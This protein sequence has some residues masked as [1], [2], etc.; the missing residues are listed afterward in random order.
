MWEAIGAVDWQ[1]ENL[2]RSWS[3]SLDAARPSHAGARVR[4][5]R[6]NAPKWLEILNVEVGWV[7]RD[8][9]GGPADATLSPEA[10]EAV[11]ELKALG[12]RSGSPIDT[13]KG[14]RASIVVGTVGPSG[15]T[16]GRSINA[17]VE[18]AALD[19]AEKLSLANADEHHLFVW[20]D[21]TD[22]AGEAAMVT[23]S[24]PDQGPQLP[25]AVDVVWVA[26]WMRDINALTNVHSLWRT[27]QGGLWEVVPVPPSRQYAQAITNSQG[28]HLEYLSDDDTD[29]VL[30]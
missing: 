23:F 28:E 15:W 27:N 16:D 20:I 17:A 11:A 21:S 7:S 8:W 6:R 9:F 19:N 2:T 3:V 13:M 18:K 1:V 5:F 26:L 30:S 29:G 22:N 4:N 12:V 10:Q 14:A 24:I 25:D